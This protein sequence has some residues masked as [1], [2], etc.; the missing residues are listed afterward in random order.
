MFRVTPEY[1]ALSRR[2]GRIMNTDV[3][4]RISDKERADFIETVELASGGFDTLPERFKELILAGEK[5]REIEIEK[6]L[7]KEKEA[8]LF[9][10][11]K[12]K[13]YKEFS[14][15]YP[16]EIDIDGKTYPTVEHY[17]QAWKA[18]DK[19]HHEKIREA[20]T[21]D[22]AKQL[23]KSIKN[24]SDW[25]EI[26]SDVMFNGVYAKFTQNEE[27]KKLLL[28]TGDRIIHEH[29]RK[30]KVWGW[31]DWKGEDRL[32]RILMEVRKKILIQTEKKATKE[33]E[34]FEITKVSVK[35]GHEKKEKENPENRIW[36]EFIEQYF[37]QFME[38]FFTD[39]YEKI[40][41]TKKITFQD[42][43]LER[44]VKGRDLWENTACKPVKCHLKNKKRESFMLYI[45]VNKREENNL[46]ERIKHF[47]GT[48]N[49]KCHKKTA[50]IVILTD[51]KG[52][53]T[54]DS[55][56]VNQQGNK[57]TLKFP[58]MNRPEELGRS[59]NP[60]A[61]V[62][63]IYPALS[64]IDKNDIKH[65]YSTKLSLAKEIIKS[66]KYNRDDTLYM[67]SFLNALVILPEELESKF[68]Y[69]EVKKMSFKEETGK[70][71]IYPVPVEVT[72]EERDTCPDCDDYPCIGTDGKG[73]SY[74]ECWNC[75]WIEYISP[76]KYK[77]FMERL[78][79]IF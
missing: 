61:M 47:Y 10:D 36:E 35:E 19:E 45:E 1:V 73:N 17:F 27:L 30:D 53:F 16:S 7:K 60:F 21:P 26:K 2:A 11:Y 77:R 22:E 70:D 52:H 40:D 65:L 9:Y 76:E 56:K 51:S 54:A 34:R 31:Y 23:G 38:F 13:P 28:S 48:G 59:D 4:F 42:K 55:Y 12:T 72:E 71:L 39:I 63:R 25:E 66:G 46:S 79:E 41:F 75:G 74:Y 68:Y 43:E 15:F 24:R 33:P 32:G 29:T 8:I 78:Q 44:V 3:M 62:V 49:D 50:A 5:E 20:K 18:T 58:V 57:L 37:P 64:E 67:L 6:I 69:D 14:N